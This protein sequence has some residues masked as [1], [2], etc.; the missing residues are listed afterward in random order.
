MRAFHNRL[1]QA[2]ICLPRHLLT[3]VLLLLGF[4]KHRFESPTIV[5][6]TTGPIRNVLMCVLSVLTLL[7]LSLRHGNLDLML[8]C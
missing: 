1:S 6:L 7:T 3:Q 8:K 5:C 2:I 4:A